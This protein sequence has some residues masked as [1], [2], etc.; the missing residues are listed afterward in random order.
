MP[1][2]SRSNNKQSWG[3]TMNSTPLRNLLLSLLAEGLLMGLVFWSVSN[4]VSGTIAVA[5]FIVIGIITGALSYLM[6]SWILVSKLDLL[7]KNSQSQISANNND[8]IQHLADYINN[9]IYEKQTII[10]KCSNTSSQLAASMDELSDGAHQTN[11]GTK[12]QQQEVEQAAT[13]MNEMSAT[14]QEI[15]LNASNAADAAT[16]ADKQAQQ[17][18]EMFTTTID[19][20]NSLATGVEQA[21][22]AIHTLEKDS[23][24][25]SSVLDVIRGIAEQTNLLA[26]NAAIEAARAGEQGRGFAVV[27][28]E[29]RTLASRTQESTQEIQEMIERLQSGSRSAVCAMTEGKK[30]A[31]KVVEQAAEAGAALDTIT[32]AVVTINTMNSQIATASE[33]Q[34]AVAEEI[35]RNVVSIAQVVESTAGVAEQTSNACVKLTDIISDLEAML[36]KYQGANSGLNLSAAK[37]AHLAW[38]TKLRSFLDGNA[39]LTREQAVSHH[40]CAFG[41]WYYSEGVGKYGSINELKEIESPHA[42]LHA[43]IKEIISC[44][45]R[46]D[47]MRA[48]ELYKQIDPLSKK[49]VGLIDIVE[50]KAATYS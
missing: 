8:V 13:A 42:K 17:G 30:K 1:F 7:A 24:A 11:E 29:V 31:N 4:Y 14:V 41:K 43:L 18:R 5:V 40:D 2:Q 6:V 26:L 27:A 10:N 32:D 38:K 49:I 20:I 25:I 16:A 12:T 47:L 48:Q 37:S 34:S 9:L 21:S 3:L 28:D 22:E 50:R 15:A 46:G 35:N 36:R 45:E 39:T 44:K 19:A 33:G 23:E